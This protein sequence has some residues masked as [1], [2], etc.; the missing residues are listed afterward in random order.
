MWE[1][2]KQDF[3]ERFLNFETAKGIY[4]LPAGLAGLYVTLFYLQ[5]ILQAFGGAIFGYMV[6][7]GFRKITVN[8][9]K[10]SQKVEELTQKRLALDTQASLRREG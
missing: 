9:I 4:L 10:Q 2:F 6:F 7:E 5:F 8:R 3:Q 1:R